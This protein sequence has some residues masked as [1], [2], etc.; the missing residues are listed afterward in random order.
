VEITNIKC[1]LKW[2]NDVLI[3]EKKVCG[4]LVDVSLESKDKV[5]VMGI[6]INVNNEA[7]SVNDNL[8]DNSIIATSLKKEY[9]NKIDLVHLT[10]AI[11]D[12]IE[13][14]YYDLLSTGKTLEI[15]DLWKKNSDIIGKRGIVYDGN[16][17]V[18][19]KVIDI[20]KDGSLLMKLDD[21]SIKRVMFYTNT[22]FR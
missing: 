11:I 22:F 8:T 15:I 14:Y 13:Y 7:S 5:I 6:G 18:V 10:K 19:G 4:I 20:D 9:G 1:T 12:R 3:N 2:P 17:K 16:E 21:S